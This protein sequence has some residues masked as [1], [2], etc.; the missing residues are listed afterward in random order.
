MDHFQII[1]IRI[2]NQCHFQVPDLC[3]VTPGDITEEIMTMVLQIFRQLL[4]LDQRMD[5]DPDL[6]SILQI[7]KSPQFLR[8]IKVVKK[9]ATFSQVF[10]PIMKIEFFPGF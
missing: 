10:L 6:V 2:F 5:T 1:E 4:A 9:S 7:L 3:P 8:D